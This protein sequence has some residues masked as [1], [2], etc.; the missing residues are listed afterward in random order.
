MANPENSIYELVGMNW[1]RSY[2][3]PTAARPTPNKLRNRAAPPI[4]VCCTLAWP[5][6]HSVP[7]PV[8]RLLQERPAGVRA[9]SWNRTSPRDAWTPTGHPVAPS[10]KVRV[11]H[12]AEGL[13]GESL[14]NRL[15]SAAHSKADSRSGVSP[16]SRDGDSGVPPQTE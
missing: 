6:A 2:P 4:R 7:V 14:E 5:S 15:P 8:P 16:L 13:A 9:R 1:S 3:V 11:S 12:W 10:Y